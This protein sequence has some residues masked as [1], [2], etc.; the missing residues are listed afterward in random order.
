VR[1]ATIAFFVMGLG[2]A[3]DVALPFLARE[4]GGGDISVGVVYASVAAGLI[5]GF[6]LLTRLHLAVA[7][8]VGF[9]AGAL[10]H[11]A[12]DLLT[13][14]AGTIAL[15]VAFQFVRG[16]GAAAIDVNL[17]TLLQRSVPGDMLGRVFANVY[18]SVGIAAA[19]STGVAGVVVDATSPGTV[20]VLSGLF[21]IAGAAAGLALTR[22]GR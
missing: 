9:V 5:A 16:I 7:P 15:V 12:G 22:A 17:Q 4:V 19:I 20:L 2:A 8:F 18:G 10:V 13:G 14:L 6:A 11:G 1:A 21:G 3:N